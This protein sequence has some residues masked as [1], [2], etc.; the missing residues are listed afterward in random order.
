MG[1]PARLKHPQL[2]NLRVFRVTK[3]ERVLILYLPLENGVEI[4]RA[5]H[6][7]RNVRSLFRRRE[8]LG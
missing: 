2:R 1:W 5:V 8:E 6:G 7:S 3:F 4:L